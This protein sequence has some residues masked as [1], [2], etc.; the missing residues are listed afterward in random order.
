MTIWFDMDGTIADLYSVDGWL[1]D[2]RAAC[3]RPYEQAACLLNMSQLAKLLHKAQRHGYE[4]GI[5]SWTSKGGNAEYNA[6]VEAAKRA[7]LAR[8]LPSVK[9]DVISIVNYGT[10][11]FEICGGG[12]LFD[13][14]IQNRISWQ[15]ESYE[16]NQIINILKLLT[17]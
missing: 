16:P 14:E 7:W 6:A 8:H 15:G 5:I 12:I 9:W 2:L 13:D 11:K 17:F 10:N 3:T 1:E 4:I